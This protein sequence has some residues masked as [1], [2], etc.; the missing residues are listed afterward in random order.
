MKRPLRY[1][2]TR[3]WFPVGAILVLFYFLYHLVE[4]DHGWRAWQVLQRQLTMAE[5]V[6]E[7]RQEQKEILEHRVGLLKADHLDPDLLEERVRAMLNHASPQEIIV[8]YDQG[9][10]EGGEE[11]ENEKNGV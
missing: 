4:G 9:E 1:H 7:D 6:L 5:E 11:I 2:L 8:L 3:L 10:E